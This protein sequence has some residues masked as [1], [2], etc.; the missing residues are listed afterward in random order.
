MFDNNFLFFQ[1]NN[2]F[3]FPRCLHSLIIYLQN[4]AKQICKTRLKRKKKLLC[5]CKKKYL[6]N[7]PLRI[8]D[9]RRPELK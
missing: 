9:N 8:F 5:K 2:C 4:K 7:L 3:F 1:T 6:L